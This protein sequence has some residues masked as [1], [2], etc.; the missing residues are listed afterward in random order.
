ME[1]C[2]MLYHA[3]V[4]G[5]IGAIAFLGSILAGAPSIPAALLATGA[6]LCAAAVS[7]AA[8]VRA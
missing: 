5:H 3:I 4:A 2:I 8:T 6:A 1:N 7:I